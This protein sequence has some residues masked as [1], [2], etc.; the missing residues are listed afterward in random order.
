MRLFALRGA[1]TVQENR[2]Q[3][4]LAA[5]DELMRELMERNSLSAD[6]IVSCIFT[7]T[8][9]LDAEFPAVAAR[10]WAS[11]RYRSCAPGRCPSQGPAPR[12]SRA[13]SLLRRA[14]HLPAARLPA[15][16]ARAASR[17]RLGTIVTWRSSS[18]SGLR[19]SRFTRSRRGYQP[20]YR[21][22]CWPRTSRALRPLPEVVEA[23]RR[24]LDGANRYPDPS[25]SSLRLR[26][27]SATGYLPSG[28]PWGM[29]PATSCWPP[30][31]RCS[32]RGPRSC[33]PGRP[34]AVYPH[35][36]AASGARAIEVALTAG[37]PRPGC[38]G[39]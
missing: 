14:D 7:L 31:R 32:S 15:R 17:S 22:P 1:N 21:S 13:G 24:M 8:E 30:E 12:H 5:T 39:P 35:L 25:Y 16:R 18:R 11:G 4:I 2:R 20:R 36:A 26:C 9:D 33:T 23:A 28:L 38:D 19:A 29:V 27:L 37:A 34:S 10:S 6:A 3:A